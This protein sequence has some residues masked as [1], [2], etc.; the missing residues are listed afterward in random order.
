MADSTSLPQIGVPT[1]IPDSASPLQNLFEKPEIMQDPA[2]SDAMNVV[3]I[4]PEGQTLVMMSFEDARV[5][6]LELP[7]EDNVR[8][9]MWQYSSSTARPES[10][11]RI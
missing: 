3:A 11:R 10:D 7:L 6:V 9:C 1:T 5:A 8:G 2:D 4:V